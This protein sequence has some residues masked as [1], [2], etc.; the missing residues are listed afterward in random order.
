MKF[1]MRVSIE[2]NITTKLPEQITKRVAAIVG[3]KNKNVSK[4]EDTEEGLGIDYEKI[5]EVDYE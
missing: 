5:A 1:G 2:E 3:V 4:V